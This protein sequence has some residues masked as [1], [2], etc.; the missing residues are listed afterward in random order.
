MFDEKEEKARRLYYLL[1]NYYLL[2]I[3][4]SQKENCIVVV[5]RFFPSTLAYHN[6]SNSIKIEK[7]NTI[8]IPSFF[9]KNLPP[10]FFIFFLDLDEN[11]RRKRIRNRNIPLTKEEILLEQDDSFREIVIN[12][13]KQLSGTIRIDVDQSLGEIALIIRNY[14]SI[15]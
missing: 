9:Q 7:E 13:Y 10:N 2:Q 1:A 4:S 12:T 14:L 5:D 6:A 11:V 3:I 15:K 8:Q